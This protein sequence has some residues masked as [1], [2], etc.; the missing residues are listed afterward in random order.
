MYRRFFGF[1]GKPF[2]IAPDPRFLYLS[3]RHREALAHLLFGLGEGGGFVQLTGE[4]GTGKT[5][6]CRALL[7]QLPENVDVVLVFNPRVDAFELVKGIC[8]ELG[9]DYP[10]GTTSLKALVDTLNAHLIDA[11]ARG[12]RTVLLIDEAQNLDRDVL[13]QIRLLTNLETSEEKLL[14]ILLIGQP[15]LRELL[16]RDDLRQLAQRIT[17][18]YHLDPLSLEETR[19]YI[20]HRLRVCQGR[21]D[22]FTPQ[23][24]ELVYRLSGG[25]PRLINI[26]CDRALLG[27]YVEE[28][29]QVGPEIVRRA[30]A[31][32]LPE[33]TRET[34]E[35]EVSSTRSRRAGLALGAAGLLVLLLALV[36]LSRNEIPLLSASAPDRLSGEQTPVPAPAAPPSVRQQA[37]AAASPDQMA[38]GA[39]VTAGSDVAEEDATTAGTKG[40]AAVGTIPATV[41]D[42]VSETVA[43]RAIPDT[44]PA[45]LVAR[46]ATLDYGD[47]LAAWQQ[48][49]R[50]W[51]ATF[52]LDSDQT[53]CEQAR[54]QGLRCLSQR[55]NWRRLRAHDRPAMLDLIRDDGSHARAL[56][57]RWPQGELPEIVLGARRLRMPAEALDRW[58]Y[59]DFVILWRP[60]TTH[61][62]LRPGDRG[63]DILWVRRQLSR[64]FGAEVLHAEDPQRFDPA[65]VEAVRRFQAARGLKPDGIIGAQTL[66]HLNNLDPEYTGPRLDEPEA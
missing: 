4:V 51:D 37:P 7:E 34:L 64:L 41:P 63:P 3:D 20:Q 45:D 50:R 27:A 43:D 38:A 16:A 42:E 49:F 6:L 21:I 59:G 60:R 24:I 40:A 55:G 22:I 47:T 18:R 30:A 35:D 66:I 26:L 44:A 9:L 11:H 19:A 17:A 39:P 8:D 53:P 14:Q 58:W 2:S 10:E 52:V 61:T 62:L 54:A 5:T 48:M 23:A 15:E 46:V 28:T 36:F 25:I 12:R 65:L 32:V 33:A 13:E 56:V 1:R 57:S 31:E 29:R